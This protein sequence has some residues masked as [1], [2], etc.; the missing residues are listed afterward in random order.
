MG[1]EEA[2]EKKLQAQFDEW[3]SEIDK[4]KAK[5]DKAEPDTQLEY[6]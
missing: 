6:Y 4:P 2:H 3:N 1:M 5:A